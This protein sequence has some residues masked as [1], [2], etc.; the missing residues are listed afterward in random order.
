MPLR[1]ATIIASLLLLAACAAPQ[2]KPAD[3]GLEACDDLE[4]LIADL[5]G[6][7][8]FGFSDIDVVVSSPRITRLEWHFYAFE[9]DEPYAFA[10][11]NRVIG[12]TTGLGD[13]A[14]NDAQGAGV[15]AHE[16]A[17][18]MR[19]GPERSAICAA[20]LARF[21]SD[22]PNSQPSALAFIDAVIALETENP[23]SLEEETAADRDGLLYVAGAGHTPLGT[24]R[25]FERLA[26]QNGAAPPR[27]FLV[28]PPAKDRVAALRRHLADAMSYYY[29][30]KYRGNPLRD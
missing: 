5:D 8:G 20:L 26:A 23:Y 22:D 17:H 15:A 16:I 24:I 2:Q 10:L 12:V 1:P 30:R 29:A 6:V 19:A 28:H 3:P 14:L 21:Q 11:P 9:D 27:F 18:V 4:S 7:H 13:L 25:V